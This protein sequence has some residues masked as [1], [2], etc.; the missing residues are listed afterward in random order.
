MLQEEARDVEG[1]TFLKAAS[2]VAARMQSLTLLYAESMNDKC[3][4]GPPLV[5]DRSLTYMRVYG[6]CD[7]K[8]PELPRGYIRFDLNLKQKEPKMNHRQGLLISFS[9]LLHYFFICNNVYLP[10]KEKK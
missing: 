2:G 7:Y 1:V 10:E 8:M 3:L 9:F 6:T 4:Y 5:S